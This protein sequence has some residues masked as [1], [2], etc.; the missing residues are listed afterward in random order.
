MGKEF[1]KYLQIAH[2]I[3][4]ANTYQKKGMI[5]L[6]SQISQSLLRF[7]DLVRVD[8]LFYNAGV[9]CKKASNLTMAFLLLNRYLDI[10]EVIEDNENNGNLAELGEF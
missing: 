10:F 3:N 1:S 2:L 9:A 4:L 5:P 6:F 8:K 7:S